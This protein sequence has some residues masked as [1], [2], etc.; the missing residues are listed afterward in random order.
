MYSDAGSFVDLCLAG[1]V[2]PVDIDDFVEAWHAGASKKD[3]WDFLGL[4]HEEYGRWVEEPDAID[5][6]VDQRRDASTT[7]RM[8]IR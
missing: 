8:M 3:V 7:R 6:I 4:T 5:D 2:R 1:K